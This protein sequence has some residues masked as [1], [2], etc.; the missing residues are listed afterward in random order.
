M[1]AAAS[2]AG[3]CDAGVAPRHNSS[4]ASQTS[5]DDSMRSGSGIRFRA[6]PR[7]PIARPDS[8]TNAASASSAYANVCR[9]IEN[10]ELRTKN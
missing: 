8:I 1:P 5:N 6:S 3:G 9:F 7:L 2:F 4:A 10:R